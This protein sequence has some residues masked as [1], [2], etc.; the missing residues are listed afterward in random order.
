M[1]DAADPFADIPPS[2]TV[3]IEPPVT[4]DGREYR[5]LVLREPRAGEVRQADE[6]VRNG[7]TM[8]NLRNREHHL[9]SKVSGV[10]LPVIEKLGI[11][12]ITLAMEYLNRFFLDG[13]P[14]TGAI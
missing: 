8:S 2:M 3:A 5:E 14:R 6:Q 1:D 12:R 7:A 13:G 10:P 11:S 9:V 4:F